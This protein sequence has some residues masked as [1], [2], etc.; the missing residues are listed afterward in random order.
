MRYLALIVLTATVVVS[1]ISV[2]YVK[3]ESRKQFVLLQS[4]ERDRDRLQVDWNR[5]Q[6]EYSAWATHDRIERVATSSLALH[7]PRTRSVVLV[8]R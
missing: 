1:A 3:H 5:L 8:T 2:I 4:L 6:L 7:A